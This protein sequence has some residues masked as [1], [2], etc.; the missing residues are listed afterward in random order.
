MPT[1]NAVGHGYRSTQSP[2]LGPGLKTYVVNLRRRPDRR[3]HIEELCKKLAL[4]YEFVDAVD[5]QDLRQKAGLIEIVEPLTRKRNT[6]QA[7]P[8]VPKVAQGFK[9][10]RIR[11]YR[12]CWHDGGI[13]RT[14]LLTMAEHRLRPSCLTTFG[15]ELWGAVG[16]SLSH[17]EVL[18]RLYQ[19][20]D[21]EWALVLEDDAT[22]SESPEEACVAFNEEMHFL[23]RQHPAWSLVY[24]GGHISTAVKPDVREAGR[25][26]KRVIS[27]QQVYQTHAFLIHKR[28]APVI[29]QKLEHGLAADAA[30]VSWSRRSP[31]ACFMFFPNQ[32][33][34]Q[35]GGPHR[36]KDSDI[37]VDG[38]FF[39]KD[40]ETNGSYEFAQAAARIGKPWA[41]KSRMIA[42]IERFNDKDACSTLPVNGGVPKA[43]RRK[44]AVRLSSL[45][46]QESAQNGT[47]G[48]VECV[49][50]APL[51]DAKR[52]KCAVAVFSPLHP[53]GKVSGVAQL[54]QGVSKRRK[55]EV[56]A[57][58]PPL[59]ETA[60]RVRRGQVKG[61]DSFP[62][63][64]SVQ[65]VKA[66]LGD[67]EQVVGGLGSNVRDMLLVA[68][69]HVLSANASHTDAIHAGALAVVR[70][71]LDRKSVV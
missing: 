21:V 56:E 22:L 35:P 53:R 58:S 9:G 24:L 33:L 40:Q 61:P 19:N 30:Y 63:S 31:D 71:A 1:E 67:G 47:R 62:N 12:A 69:P 65:K 59:R 4:D 23:S 17:Q 5:G 32:L 50:P 6:G 70:A 2:T 13:Q 43:K 15:H 48:A 20:V 60:Q 57:P 68:V 8:V 38:E 44:V 7:R 27:V 10:L 39:K 49:S 54:P 46:P 25:V 42:E 3:A 64:E 55:K 66:V 51:P 14:Q 41:T 52:R 29:L 28:I 37:F 26:S 34:K 16:C 36:W 11:K 45:P 18:N